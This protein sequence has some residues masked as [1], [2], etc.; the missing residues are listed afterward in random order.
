MLFCE[1]TFWNGNDLY[2]ANFG[3][4]ALNP[5]N[6]EGKGYIA[7]YKDGKVTTLIPADGNLSAPKGMA[8]KNN[9]LFIADVS[10]IV[11]YNLNNLTAAPQKISFS[12]DDDFVNDL[13]IKDNTL[14]ATVTRTNKV[15]QIDISN[16]QNLSASKPTL[17]VNVAGP[18]GIYIDNNTMYIASYAD[19]ATAD[20]VIYTIDMT[21]ATL[22]PTKFIEQSGGYDG[23]ALSSD[24]KTLYFTDWAN[25]GGASGKVGKIDVN[26]KAITYYD[27]TVGGPARLTLHNG[28]LYVPD[29]PNSKVITIKVD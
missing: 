20:N 24:A 28:Y 11:V 25:G 29:L 1:S 13:A 6:T 10:V 19:M 8:L 2:I 3:S 27:V 23:L 26:T 22:A 5:L 16:L 14:Y 21:Q 7:Q 4:S 9:Y 17:Y 18:N 15:Y 12:K